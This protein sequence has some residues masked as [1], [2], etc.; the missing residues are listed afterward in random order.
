MMTLLK[1]EWLRLKGFRFFW[2]FLSGYFLCLLMILWV[3]SSLLTELMAGVSLPGMSSLSFSQTLSLIFYL[4]GFFE[5]FLALILIMMICNDHSLGTLKQHVIDGLSLEQVTLG[6]LTQ[7]ALLVFVSFVM[8]TGLSFLFAGRVSGEG[9]EWPS[10]LQ[11][12]GFC[13]RSLGLLSFSVLLASLIKRA[14]PTVLAYFG[15]K[16]ILEPVIGY[17]LGQYI[18]IDVAQY[19][20]LD[21]FSSLVESPNDILNLGGMTMP[22]ME[23]SAQIPETLPFIIAGLYFILIWGAIYALVKTRRFN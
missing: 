6:R 19:L 5:S 13:L 10:W 11:V 9:I 23:A 7:V 22:G 2:I 17:T 18:E 4:S 21:V 20:P 12:G 8:V 1:L 14:I 15:L 3:G 16:L